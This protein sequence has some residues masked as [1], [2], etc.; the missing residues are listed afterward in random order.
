M[1]LGIM[2]NLVEFETGQN[3]I[4][5]KI[6]KNFAYNNCMFILT[7]ILFDTMHGIDIRDLLFL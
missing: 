4:N 7:E 6:G 1:L 3:F 2:K 5:G